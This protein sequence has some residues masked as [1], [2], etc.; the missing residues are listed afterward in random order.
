MFDEPVRAALD[1]AALDLLRTTTQSKPKLGSN[2]DSSTGQAVQ[3]PGQQTALSFN[4]VWSK[5]FYKH[6]RQED[7]EKSHGIK[8]MT[9][10]GKWV[11]TKLPICWKCLSK[12]HV[13]HRCTQQLHR[14]AALTQTGKYKDTSTIG[15]RAFNKAVELHGNKEADRTRH[16]LKVLEEQLKIRDVRATAEAA[17]EAAAGAPAEGNN[18]AYPPLQGHPSEEEKEAAWKSGKAAPNKSLHNPTLEQLQVRCT[19]GPFSC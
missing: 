15:L 11:K 18:S 12:D 4:E 5:E 1:Q 2:D 14:A 8:W 16:Y 10:E 3:V 19:V 13:T 6:N 7:L 9:T 17:T